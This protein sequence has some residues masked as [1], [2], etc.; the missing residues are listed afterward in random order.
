MNFLLTLA[1]FG[2]LSVPDHSDVPSLT[3]RDYLQNAVRDA[4][5]QFDL[6]LSEE[7]A[8]LEFSVFHGFFEDLDGDGNSEIIV[9]GD[10]VGKNVYFVLAY[11]WTGSEW[12]C[13]VLNRSQG[14]GIQDIRLADLD[15]DGRSEV[16]SVLTN[17]DGSKNCSVY[18]FDLTTRSFSPA[19]QMATEAG[20]Q[21]SCNFMLYRGEHAYRL[22]VDQ[23]WYPEEEGE[24]VRTNTML[25]VM[26]G[27]RLVRETKE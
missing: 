5:E 19:F 12:Q 4:E 27:G 11:H 23:V 25:F 6:R 13:A 21:S 15:Q 17:R 2:A 16:Y 14:G 7:M 8:V 22:R 9:A 1:C 20:F 3:S 10:I 26:D 18:S 24:S